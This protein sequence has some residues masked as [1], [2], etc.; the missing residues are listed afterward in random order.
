MPINI[1]KLPMP[2]TPPSPDR[3]S[4]LVTSDMPQRFMTKLLCTARTSISFLN[5]NQKET[6]LPKNSQ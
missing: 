6:F 3:Y 5:L 2:N 1:Q 4:L